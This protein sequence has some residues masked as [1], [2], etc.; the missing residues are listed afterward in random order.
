MNITPSILDEYM[1]KLTPARDA[2]L[3]EMETYGREHEF[4]LIG[5]LCGRFLQQMAIVSGA[6]RIIEL[7]SGFGYSTLWFAAG[8]PD[9]G[10]IICTDGDPE[11]KK[12]ALK[13]FERVGILDKIEFYTGQALDILKKYDGPFDIILNDI[14]KHQYPEVLDI[15]IPRLRKGGLLITDNVLWYGRVVQSSQNDPDTEGVKLFNEMLYQRTDVFTTILP[16]RDGLAVS[17]KV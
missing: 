3:Q 17:A 10:K 4:P 5:P 2:V 7:G 1:L 11:N 16:L 15:A 6:K 13:Y 14:D 12:R 9:D 8:I